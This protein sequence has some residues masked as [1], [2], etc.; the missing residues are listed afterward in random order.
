MSVFRSSAMPAAFAAAL[1]LF[2][3][4]CGPDPASAPPPGGGPG[5]H[6]F[7][8]GD[9]SN[10]GLIG[11]SLPGSWRPF[12][13]D[14]PWNT[15]IPAGAREHPDSALIMATLR[16]GSDR[17][18]LI[19]TY[20]CPIWVV[21]AANVAGARVRSDRIFNTW[22]QDRDGWSDA[23]VPVTRAMYAEPTE[24]GQICIVDPF[25]HTLWDISTYRWNLWSE[26]PTATTLDVWDLLDSGV[27]DPP[28]GTDWILRGGRGSGFPGIAG[29]IRPEELEAGRIRHA[30]C[31]SFNKNRQGPGGAKIFLPPACRSDGRWV[32]PEY[33]I[34]GMRFQLDPALTESDF[35][36]WGLNRE[37]KIVARALQEYGMF[38]GLT[39]GAMKLEVQ[40]LGR[41]EVLNRLEW[42]RRFPGFYSNVDRIPTSA[43]RAVYTGEPKMRTWEGGLRADNVSRF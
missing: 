21:N 11:N 26:N 19:S 43:L 9:Y 38:L 36:R 28:E 17:L 10:R 27:A 22:D 32:G 34:E 15:P 7:Y 31:F 24:D 8:P 37:G 39:G 29:M 35:D 41:N 14:S 18:R 23:P 33:P 13:D 6:D 5:N 20:A 12:A 25:T 40:L 42:E 16:S 2:A 30:L 4:S 3:T 1:T